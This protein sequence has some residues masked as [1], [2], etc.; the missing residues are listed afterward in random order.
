MF[1]KLRGDGD[2][3]DNDRATSRR[4]WQNENPRY[5]ITTGQQV[6][7][8]GRTRIQGTD[9]SASTF[10]KKRWLVRYRPEKQ[11]K[12]YRCHGLKNN[13]EF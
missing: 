7:E 4:E 12:I 10:I 8:N 2:T 13:Y 6:E 5:R 1:V 9:A 11:R 3:P